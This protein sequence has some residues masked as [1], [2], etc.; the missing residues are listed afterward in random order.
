MQLG[1]APLP[2]LTWALLPAWWQWVEP[3]PERAW[4]YLRSTTAW[5]LWLEKFL[6]PQ[7]QTG[8]RFAHHITVVDGARLRKLSKPFCVSVSSVASRTC[9]FN[10][11]MVFYKSRKLFPFFLTSVSFVWQVFV[12]LP[13][14][15][16]LLL[17]SEFVLLL[18]Y[19][20]LI[21]NS[22]FLLSK[23]T[24]SLLFLFPGRG[25]HVRFL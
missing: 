4:T 13:V 3:S 15:Q 18:L 21:L 5:W 23:F 17:F 1:D 14:A 22:L 11:F 2:R 19:F 7:A 20:Y 12:D 16:M 25:C 9:L 24:F 10:Y 6:R 8:S